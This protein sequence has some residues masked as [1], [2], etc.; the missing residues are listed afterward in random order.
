MTTPIDI[1]DILSD[2]REGRQIGFQTLLDRISEPTRIFRPFLPE[3]R[4]GPLPVQPRGPQPPPNTIVDP[5]RPTPVQ[6]TPRIPGEDLFRPGVVT[7]FNRQ[8]ISSSLFPAAEN[9]FFGALGRRI[10]QGQD[11]ITFTDFLNNDFNLQRR[12]RRTPSQQVGSSISRLTS[13]A[14]FLFSQ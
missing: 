14:R 3:G 12:I 9:E 4:S 1:F 6:G 7:P 11:P 10:E 5:T 2:T 13:P 8:F